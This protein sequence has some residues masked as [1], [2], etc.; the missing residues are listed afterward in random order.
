MEPVSTRG[1]GH[2]PDLAL[3]AGPIG[4]R[5]TVAHV[6]HV[7]DVTNLESASI[8]NRQLIVRTGRAGWYHDTRGSAI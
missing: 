2:S 8:A 4:S 6:P 3:M 1:I 7:K 5:A